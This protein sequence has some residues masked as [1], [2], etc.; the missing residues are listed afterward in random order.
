MKKTHAYR[1]YYTKRRMCVDKTFR[2]LQRTRRSTRTVILTAISGKSLK[3]TAETANYIEATPSPQN[4]T[5]FRKHSCERKG[6]RD[7]NGTIATQSTR[8]FDWP[9]MCA[10]KGRLVIEEEDISKFDLL[11]R[12]RHKNKIRI[13]TFNQ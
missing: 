5:F 2:T 1:K 9:C 10:R 4:G 12:I 13:I 3:H 8:L 6:S 11:Y 7:P